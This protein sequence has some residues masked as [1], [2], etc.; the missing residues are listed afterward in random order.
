MATVSE[1]LVDLSGTIGEKVRR[2]FP[3]SDLVRRISGSIKDLR[4]VHGVPEEAMW[5]TSCREAGGTESSDQGS[6]VLMQQ[7]TALIP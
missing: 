2:E 5:R 1:V 7:G 3:D 6:K 4:D